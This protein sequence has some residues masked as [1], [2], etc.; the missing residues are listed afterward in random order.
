MKLRHMNYIL[1]ILFSVFQMQIGFTQGITLPIPDNTQQGSEQGS[2]KETPADTRPE[3]QKGKTS[4][5]IKTQ[6]NSYE[7]FGVPI[8]KIID[9]DTSEPKVIGF[10]LYKIKKKYKT[11]NNPCFECYE[12]EDRCVLHNLHANKKQYILHIPPLDPNSIYRLKKVYEFPPDF[13]SLLKELKKNSDSLVSIKQY[14]TTNGI[15]LADRWIKSLKFINKK[16][17]N[18]T[19]YFSPS[20]EQLKN[21]KNIQGTDHSYIKNQILMLIPEMATHR[22]ES[23]D[24]FQKLKESIKK[25]RDTQLIEELG[26]QEY[27]KLYKDVDWVRLINFYIENRSKL[28]RAIDT[29]EN[30]NV[31]FNMIKFFDTFDAEQKAKHFIEDKDHFISNFHRGLIEISTRKDILF[32]SYSFDFMTRAKSVITPD[33]GLCYYPPL[34][35]SSLHGASPFIGINISLKPINKNIPYIFSRKHI[36]DWLSFHLGFTLAN[37]GHSSDQ[38]SS[39][40]WNQNLIAGVGLKPFG[41]STRILFGTMVFKKND[42][43]RNISELALAPQM[44]ISFDL[45]IGKWLHDIKVLPSNFISK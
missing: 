43:F 19:L 6:N 25:I 27:L 13:I 34:L 20:A 18:T 11:Y 7:H 28:D 40:F 14:K 17:K 35:G 16:L 24:T 38:V 44:S 4:D 8:M 30:S 3:S 37:I 23:K 12:E 41:H 45:E 31:Q 21:I 5:T 33:F 36:E 15:I 9:L 2:T 32:N 42:P 1:A 10:K 29:C 39:L 22:L 26:T